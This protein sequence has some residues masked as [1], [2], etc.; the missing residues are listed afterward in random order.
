MDLL[1][2]NPI[3]EN[4]TKK[5]R[6]SL[7]VVG[8]LI[9]ILIIA[10][11]GIYIYSLQVAKDQFKVYVDGTRVSS[12]ENN[13]VFYLRDDKMFVSINDIANVIGYRVYNGEYRQYSEDTTSGYATNSKEL[14]TFSAGA[15]S[16]RKYPQLGNSESQQFELDE[17]ILARGSKLY[18]SQ[19]GLAR[20]FNLVFVYNKNTNTVQITTLPY[21]SASYEK[22]VTNC[23]LSESKLSEEIIFNN[24]KALLYNLIVVK[25]ANTGLFGVSM[26]ENGT[27]KNVIT[28]RYTSVEFIEGINDFIV[29]TD[30]GKYGII[31][32][33][34]I[35]KVKP[36]YT[37]IQEIDKDEG[38]YL[39]ESNGKPGVVNQSGKI[40]IYQ[41]F[42]GI[43]LEGTITD[44]NVTN[45]YLLYGSVIPVQ[46]N[47]KWGLYNKNGEQILPVEY[48]GIGCSI[49]VNQTNSVGVTLIPEMDEA[50]VISKDEKVDNNTVKKYGIVSS[51]GNS[52]INIVA[53]SVYATTLQNK[54]TYYVN[55]QNQVIDIV[56]FWLENRQNVEKDYVGKEQETEN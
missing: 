1:Q 39:V 18:M 22:N 31:G 15:T 16:I 50:I 21:L 30:D 7:I 6:N 53:D 26:S 8:V 34:G 46:K 27:V 55:V 36:Q 48:D 11:I 43:G 32:N 52:L 24:Q 51:T 20:A 56:N 41:D 28:E 45:R 10:A 38:L 25:D 4:K 54:T 37:N 29:K 49:N 19:Q 5:L 12:I 33:D 42:D 44:G 47:K 35:T 14:V 13:E 17:A 23:S 2:E 9:V 3:K 40:I